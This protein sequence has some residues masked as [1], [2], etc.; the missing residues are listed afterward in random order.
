M[1]ILLT[2]ATGF[3][4]SAFTRLA[5]HRGHRVAG[6]AIPSESIPAGLPASDN[7]LWLRGTLDDAPWKAMAGFVPEVCVHTAW[8]TTP[9]V[10]LEAPENERFRDTSHLFLRRVQEL[11]AN[12]VVGLGTCIEYQISSQ[13]LSEERTPI[14]PTTLYARCKNDL[15]LALES[16]SRARGFRF[17]WARIFYPYGPGEHPSRLCTSLIAKLSRGEEVVLKTPRSTKDYIYIDDIASALLQLVEQRAEG[18]VNVGTGI[19]VTVWELAQALGRM[20]GRPELV[21]RT[22]PELPDPLGYVVAD[23]SRLRRLGWEPQYDLEQG[24]GKLL[25]A[26][27]ASTG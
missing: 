12:H 4:G 10:Y 25:A 21:K 8:I 5:L 3:I 24:L 26:V 13:P 23:S 16:D 27:R 1:R 6:L 17:C 20:L 7:L 9:G 11:G 14:T 22:E 15:R 2:G 19:G 18:G